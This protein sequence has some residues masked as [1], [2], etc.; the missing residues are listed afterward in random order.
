M[1]LFKVFVVV[2]L[3]FVSGASV[4]AGIVLSNMGLGGATNTS[5]NTSVDLTSSALIASGFMSGT[6]DQRINKINL[7]TESMSG[8]TS[9]TVSI[10]YDDAGSPGRLLGTSNP[11]TVGTKGIYQFNFS[12]PQLLAKTKYWVIPDTG[13]RWYLNNQNSAPTPRNSSGFTYLGMKNTVGGLN[14][15]WNGYAFNATIALDTTFVPEPGLTSLLCLS[16]IALIR[17]RTKK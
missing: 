3:A 8:S 14:G 1:K 15:P 12:G 2:A 4:Q 6:T 16:G 9:E 11:T 17:R 13:M 7:V 10:Y 5:S